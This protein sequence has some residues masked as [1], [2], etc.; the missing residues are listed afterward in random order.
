M[1][2][3]YRFTSFRMFDIV[4][5]GH[6]NVPNIIFDR[7]RLQSNLICDTEIKH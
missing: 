4:F 3:D 7:S 6:Y 2:I 5:A 1:N